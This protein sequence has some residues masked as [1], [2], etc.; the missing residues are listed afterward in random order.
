M[1][2]RFA[3]GRIQM[4]LQ[5]RHL[6]PVRARIRAAG[7]LQ[8]EHVLAPPRP[9]R[10][11]GPA[12]P[13]VGVGVD[14]RR[15]CR[16]ARR[17]RC[18]CGRRRT[19][20]GNRACRAAQPAGE[21]AS[22][23]EPIVALTQV[24]ARARGVAVEVLVHLEG[25]VVAGIDDLQH[26]RRVRRAVR[27]LEP[28]CRHRSSR[29]RG[30]GS[31]C[32]A[33]ASRIARS[34]RWRRRATARSACRAARSSA[35]RSRSDCPCTALPGGTRDRRTR[36]RHRPSAD[37][38]AAVARVVVRI[39]HHVC[40]LAG[41]VVDEGVDASRARRRRDSPCSAGWSR[42]QRNGSRN[43]FMPLPAK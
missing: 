39:E 17:G 12:E 32:R 24:S 7:G 22:R 28:A 36:R 27:V 37:Q 42:S 1:P 10:P 21:T 9:G 18:R 31:G 23:C 33:S 4:R 15:A 40:A 20:R 30:R 13:D 8:G 26:R 43:T 25:E 38:A 11:V 3:S 29:C 41:G 19:R 34:R 16:R 14:M 2:P 35:R 6:R 5:R